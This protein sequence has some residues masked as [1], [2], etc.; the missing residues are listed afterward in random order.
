MNLDAIRAIIER[1]RTAGRSVL[2]ET[3]GLELL[4]AMGI[5][6]PRHRFL[7]NSAEVMALEN[8]GL[9]GA[10][11]VVKVVSP[12]I[13]HKSD[14]GGVAVVAN[15]RADIATAI[16]DMETRLAGRTITGF[17]VMEFIR[18]DASLGGELLAG[19]RWTSEFGP[20]VTIGAGGITTEFLARDLREGR[21]AAIVSPHLAGDGLGRALEDVAAVALATRGFRG[22]PPRTDASRVAAVGTLLMTLAQKL[23]PQGIAEC[24]INPLAVTPSGLFALDILVTL[25]GELP[26]PPPPRPLH[27]IGRL[28]QPRR[29]ALVGVSEQLN[30]GRIILNNLLRDGFDPSSIVIVKA[31]VDSI[32]GCRCVPDVA[33]LPERVD[34]FV[35]AVSAAQVPALLRDIVAGE[36][37]ESVIVIPGGLDEKS[38]SE[39][40]V[41]EMREALVEARTADWQGPIINGG[42]CLGVRSRPGRYDTMFIP[43]F[44]LPSPAGPVSPVA[45]ISQSGAFAISRASRM[46]GLNPRYIIT[47]GNQMDVTIGDYLAFLKDERSIDVFAVYVEGFK[48]LDGLR[49]MEA[50]RQVTASGRT[51]ILYRAGRTTEGARASASHTASI[52]GDYRVTR[53]MCE[54]AGVVLAETLEDFDDLVRTFALLRDREASGLHIAALSNAGFESVAI[55]DGLGSLTLAP[56]TAHTRKRLQEILAQSR[57]DSLV[58]VHN[59]LDVTPMAG[60]SAFEGVARTLLADETVDAAV[61]G[62]VPMTVALQTLRASEGHSEDLSRPDGVVSRLARLRRETSKPWVAVVDAGELYDPMAAALEAAAIPTF[63]TADRAVR[64]LSLFSRYKARGLQAR[65]MSD[66]ATPAGAI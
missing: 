19:L 17:L 64:M 25:S 62:C 60:D 28:L 65:V 37:A 13:L 66:H 15:S 43:E 30:P 32:G 23:M 47:V 8:T 59:P 24:E 21:D 36:K 51:V 7:Q 20:V 48:P 26:S 45:V 52:A 22:R 11:V 10:N 58:D 16:H 34:L 49:F 40:I 27:K 9:P 31:G 41:R 33:S 55:A 57:I 29:V 50:A 12:E 56:L 6:R 35:V 18:H 39:T 46:A 38:G 53:A 61:I 54:Q 4:D 3:E 44:K 5:A 1:A 63:R 14:V 2:L 42:N